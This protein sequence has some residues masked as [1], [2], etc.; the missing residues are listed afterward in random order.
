MHNQ[1]K[2]LVLAVLVGI[3]G[4]GVG[5][6]CLVGVWVLD[7]AGVAVWVGVWVLLEVGVWDC[8]GVLVCVGVPVIDI[9]PFDA[10]DIPT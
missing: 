9:Y 2:F 3:V 8:V 10:I 4:V 5:V 1:K 6:G 7:I